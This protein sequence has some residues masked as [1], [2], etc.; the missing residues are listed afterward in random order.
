MG[1][2]TAVYGLSPEESDPDAVFGI[3]L[4]ARRILDAIQLRSPASIGS[5]GVSDDSLVRRL[6]DRAAGVG[7]DVGDAASSKWRG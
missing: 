4:D 2:H 1:Q 3:V 5:C 6:F 7:Y